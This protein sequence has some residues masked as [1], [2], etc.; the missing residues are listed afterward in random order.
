MSLGPAF[1][2]R[3]TPFF[4]KQFYNTVQKSIEY[5][6]GRQIRQNCSTPCQ[7]GFKNNHNLRVQ[8]SKVE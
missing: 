8:Y 4:N 7:K 5:T 6:A 2:D 3:D 1:Y